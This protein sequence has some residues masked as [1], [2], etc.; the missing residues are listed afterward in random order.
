MKPR[1]TRPPDTAERGTPLSGPARVS[2]SSATRPREGWRPKSRVRPC[3]ACNQ[4][5]I[6]SSAADRFHKACRPDLGENDGER[7]GLVR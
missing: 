2:R 1:D 3:L 7:A 5:R 4:P 6:S